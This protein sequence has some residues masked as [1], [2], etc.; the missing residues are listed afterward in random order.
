MQLD[1]QIKQLSS[2]IKIIKYETLKPYLIVAENKLYQSF[3]TREC[4]KQRFNL[5]D[6]EVTYVTHLAAVFDDQGDV[7]TRPVRIPS[8]CAMTVK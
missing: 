1:D 2:V 5:Y 3:Y 4:H 7:I 8:A 6:C